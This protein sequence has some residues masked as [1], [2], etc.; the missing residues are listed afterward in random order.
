MRADREKI[1]RMSEFVMI[2]FKTSAVLFIIIQPCALETGFSCGLL[3]EFG[4]C[5]NLVTV[6][7]SE[8]I[9]NKDEVKL[10]TERIRGISGSIHLGCS[11]VKRIHE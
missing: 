5:E 2:A 11:L 8:H 1:Q 3:T 9:A 7:V 6:K 4:G 10:N